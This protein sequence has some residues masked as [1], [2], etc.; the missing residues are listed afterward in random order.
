MKQIKRQILSSYFCL[1]SAIVTGWSYQLLQKH[2]LIYSTKLHLNDFYAHPLSSSHTDIW[3]LVSNN[4]D[5]CQISCKTAPRKKV[6]FLGFAQIGQHSDAQTL[7]FGLKT[8]INSWF[9]SFNS[10]FLSIFLSFTPTTSFYY[11]FVQNNVFF[12][13]Y[14]HQKI[15]QF[16][17]TQY[18]L[19]FF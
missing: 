19:P 18:L 15:G 16:E 5:I 7:H 17:P 13:K 14:G 3:Y 12:F 6:T 11:F 2:L 1:I 10:W 9:I 4:P 8:Q